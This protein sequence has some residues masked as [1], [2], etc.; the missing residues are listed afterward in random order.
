MVDGEKVG[1]GEA[2]E[3]KLTKAASAVKIGVTSPDGAHT[4]EYV[5]TI[6]RQ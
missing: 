4:T 5:L 1:A 3:V 2:H 6:K